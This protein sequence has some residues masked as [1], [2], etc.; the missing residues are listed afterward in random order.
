MN[1]VLDTAERA[2][3]ASQAIDAKK[4]SAK[5]VQSGDWKVTFTVALGDMPEALLMSTPGTHYKLAIVEVNDDG[6]PLPA[7]TTSKNKASRPKYEYGTADWAIQQLH[8]LAAD[9]NTW[10]LIA[11]CVKV[12]GI[13]DPIENEEEAAGTIRG[14]CNISS[15]REFR[16]DAVALEVFKS[17][18]R[19]IMVETGQWT[20]DH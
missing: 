18:H 20:E 4:D 5:Q 14:H 19:Y 1:L 8:I 17:F 7:G 12:L 6:E 10:T 9:A 3:E 2:R 13:D 15:S 11:A 16:T